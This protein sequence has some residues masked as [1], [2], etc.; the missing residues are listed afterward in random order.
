MRDLLEGKVNP[1]WHDAITNLPHIQN[2]PW[3][4]LTVS[5]GSC[6]PEWDLILAQVT[7]VSKTLAHL[8]PS[9]HVFCNGLSA[10]YFS[11]DSENPLNR[12]RPPVL[13]ISGITILILLRFIF[14]SVG[15]RYLLKNCC[16]G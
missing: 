7:Q 16:A 14:Y 9:F 13:E 5:K 12:P 4:I 8:G 6:K 15:I 2:I 10:S 3:D 1:C 11:K